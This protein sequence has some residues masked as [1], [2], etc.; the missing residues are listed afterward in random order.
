VL[1]V[2]GESLPETAPVPL[3]RVETGAP[4]L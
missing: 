4:L 3:R 1:L 2:V